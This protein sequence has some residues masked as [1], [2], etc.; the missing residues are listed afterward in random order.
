MRP[1]FEH[2]M[3]VYQIM[4][5]CQLY[6]LHRVAVVVPMAYQNGG[7]RKCEILIVCFGALLISALLDVFPK[8]F[9]T[10][11]TGVSMQV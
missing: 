9:S 10:K 3:Q 8:N 2:A 1:K 11:H 6:T 5:S 4:S 7:M